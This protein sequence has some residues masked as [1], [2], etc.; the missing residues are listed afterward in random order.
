MPV[1]F[2]LSLLEGPPAGQNSQW[3]SDLDVSVSH[4]KGLF[5]SLWMTDH[6]FWEGRPTFEAWTTLSFIASRYPDFEVGPMVLGQNYRN[7][8][9]L[10]LM[11][12]TLQTLSN[13]RFIMG[14]G[15][16]WKENEYLSYDYDYPSPKI[17][18]QQL[19]DTLIIFKKLWEE[20]G[21]VSYEGKHYSIKDA[22][23][24]PKPEI[25]IPIV[26]GGGGK[27]TMKHAAKYADIWNLSD[28]PIGRYTER[29]N[30]LKTHLDNI[31]R[32]HN[33]MRFSWFGRVA[34]GK[35]EAEAQERGNS[36]ALKWTRD[37][38]FVGTPEQ[39][40]EQ[41]SEFSEQGC[42]YFMIDIIDLPNEEIIGL[43]TE[44]LIPKVKGL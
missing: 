13:G 40:A 20:E 16:G 6:F 10:A 36:R 8:A 1:D 12:A 34:I 21:Q 41:M 14:I 7:P 39:I 35:T 4:L 15:A 9:M 32:D 23:C 44:E 31:G 5:R 37:N 17:R 2:G 11:A 26:V 19:E 42:D 30:I 25:K 28:A 3:L 22:W 18:L 33:T 29:L 27:T 38:A 43:I 24:E